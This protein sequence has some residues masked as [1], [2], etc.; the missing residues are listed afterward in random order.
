VIEAATGSGGGDR[1]VRR[2]RLDQ[3]T[4][5]RSGDGGRIGLRQPNQH[6]GG[7]D[8]ALGR[9]TDAGEAS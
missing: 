2:R 1:M 9:S 8:L 3:A 7:M 6:G 5:A 4:T